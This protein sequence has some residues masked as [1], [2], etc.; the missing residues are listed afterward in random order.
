LDPLLR[1]F[2]SYAL[3]REGQQTVASDQAGF[4]PLP[5]ALLAAERAR[6]N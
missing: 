3:S 2:L 6:I 1:E 4:L 5:A